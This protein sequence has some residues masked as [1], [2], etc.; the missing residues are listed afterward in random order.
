MAVGL[1]GCREEESRAIPGVI[2]VRRE[3][4]KDPS[5]AYAYELRLL[6]QV[7]DFKLPY[8]PAALYRQA[9]QS[10]LRTGL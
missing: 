3:A 8:D 6:L 7:C 9:S 2:E 10:D 5:T 1:H 4:Q